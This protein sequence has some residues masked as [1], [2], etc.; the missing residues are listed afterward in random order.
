MKYHRDSGLYLPSRFSQKTAFDV[1]LQRFASLGSANF[2]DGTI[3]EFDSTSAPGTTVLEAS[4]LAAKHGSYGCRIVG[5]GASSYCYGNIDF[6]AQ[7]EVYMRAYCYIKSDC[8]IAQFG[9]VSMLTIHSLGDDRLLQ[10]LMRKGTVGTGNPTQWEIQGLNLTTAQDATNF[11]LNTWFYVD[12]YWKA[13]TGA[14]GGGQVWVNGDEVFNDLDVDVSAYEADTFRVG[15]DFDYS[16]NDG[17]EF[18][19]D[20]IDIDTTGPIGAY[21]AGG[22]IVPLI[23]QQMRWRRG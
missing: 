3:N 6:T 2:N 7:S 10:F 1:D 11:A 9:E 21:D 16:L 4:A 20:T 14:N 15:M 13:G 12:M 23:M 17:G 5:D 18:Y 22:S 19:I 8:E